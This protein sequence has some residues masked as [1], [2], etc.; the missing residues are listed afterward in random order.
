MPPDD[1]KLSKN[2]KEMLQTLLST[3]QVCYGKPG[4][5]QQQVRQTIFMISLGV[6]DVS[7]GVCV[8][9]SIIDG[10]MRIADCRSPL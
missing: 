1:L 6:C 9:G 5:K 2:F 10:Y 8:G 3:G 4:K 7:G